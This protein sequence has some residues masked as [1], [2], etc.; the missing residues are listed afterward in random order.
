MGDFC[1]LHVHGGP[2]DGLDFDFF[3]AYGKPPVAGDLVTHLRPGAPVSHLY[4]VEGLVKG[5]Y[6]LVY[7]GPQQVQCRGK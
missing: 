5:G 4:R 1:E 7:V 3:A 2:A 6:K